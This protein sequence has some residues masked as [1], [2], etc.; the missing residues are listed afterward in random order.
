[1][2]VETRGWPG[3]GL[4]GPGTRISSSPGRKPLKTSPTGQAFTSLSPYGR[5]AGQ[6]LQHQ[7]YADRSWSAPM[8]LQSAAMSPALAQPQVT[9]TTTRRV[10][11]GGQLITLSGRH[12]SI[13]EVW[14]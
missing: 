11:S 8:T 5:T 10:T 13:R 2:P 12:P 6:L 1:M 14:C 3:T 7:L 9:W 4:S